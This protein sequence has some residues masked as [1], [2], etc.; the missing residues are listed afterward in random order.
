MHPT[1]ITQPHRPDQS[2][3]A[4]IGSRTLLTSELLCESIDLRAGERVLAAPAAVAA[5]PW[6]PP[7]ASAESSGSTI[8]SCWSRPGGA[9]R[10]KGWRWSS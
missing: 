7:A 5:P 3:G 6:P 8:P 10:P 9:Q 2:V 4:S 1:L